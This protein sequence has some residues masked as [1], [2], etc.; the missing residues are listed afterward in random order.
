VE[1]GAIAQSLSDINDFWSVREAIGEV[2][3]VIGPHLNF[4]IGLPP[5]A[6]GEFVCVCEAALKDLTTGPTLYVGHIGDGNLH[7][8][9]PIPEHSNDH[10]WEIENRVFGILSEREGTVTAEHG[11]GLLKREWL[12][13]TRRPEEILVMR[14]L[15]S[16]LDPKSLLNPGKVILT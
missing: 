8:I 16:C 10:T 1:D 2:D 9:V 6:L 14:H 5:S 11:V 7:V 3:H 13:R 12:N 4:D 15:K